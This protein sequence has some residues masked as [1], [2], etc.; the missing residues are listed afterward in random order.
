MDE[1]W[2][3]LGVTHGL[4]LSCSSLPLLCIHYPQDAGELG[5]AASEMGE[6]LRLLS[7]TLGLTHP[8]TLVALCNLMN[9]GLVVAEAP[10]AVS[11]GNGGAKEGAYR[12]P[13]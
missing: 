9:L 13:R 12:P 2:P 1:V 7:S 4:T 11:A 5:R 10:S 8:S 6:V 3:L